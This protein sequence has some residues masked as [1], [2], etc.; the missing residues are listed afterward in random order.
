MLETKLCRAFQAGMKLSMHVLPWRMPETLEGPGAIKQ[1]PNFMKN[2]GVKEALIVTD[3]NLMQLNLLEEFLQVMES[4]HIPY[5]IYDGVKPNPTDKNVEDAVSLYQKHKCNAI[6]AVGGGS[7][8][9]CAKAVAARIARPDKSVK[10]L[11]GVLRVMRRVPAIYAV[12]TTTGTGSETTIAAVV[13]IE[14]D[15]HKASIND[16]S[17][18]PKYAV[19]DPELT[20]GVPPYITAT[21]GMDALCHAVEAYTNNTYNTKLERELSCKAVKLIYDNLYDAYQ[22]GS[23]LY[24]RQNMQEGA[25]YAGR[26][27]SRGCVGYVHAIGHALGGLYGTAHGVA[28]AS[29]LPLVMRQY[30][31]AVHKPLAELC[32]V[33]GIQVAENTEEAKA[34]AFIRWM[35]DMKARMGIPVYPPTLEPQDID[36]IAGKAHRE[37]NPLYP[38]PVVW[39]KADFKL[40]LQKCFYEKQFQEIRENSGV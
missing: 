27:F 1:L 36:W 11:Q 29:L 3:R 30:G 22:D 25:F 37:A 26:A 40:F 33:C 21:T 5:V 19:L 4:E 28:M 6:V 34:E 16:N 24:A 8:M 14:K 10:Q 23:N 12:P 38:V 13:T 9:D 17:I 18:M 15:H 20:L 31:A 35:E 39:S 2:K 7:P 32:D